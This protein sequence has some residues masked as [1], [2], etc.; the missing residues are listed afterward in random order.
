[1]RTEIKF[2]VRNTLGL[3]L[4]SFLVSASFAQQPEQSSPPQTTIRVQTSLVLVDVITQDPK[5]GLPVRDFK[6]EDF[7]VFDKGNE[8]SIAS[9]DA[10]ARYDTRRVV[11]WLAVI[12]NERGRT[13][14][15]SQFVGKEKLFLPALNHLDKLDTVGVAH[16]CDNGETRLDLL[17]TE[18]RQKPIEILTETI[19]PI[20]FQVGGNSSQVGETT[21]RKMVRLIIQDTLRR[22]PQ[23]L[24]VI[25]FLDGDYT[26]QPLSELNELV[27]DF[28]ETSGIVFGIKDARF[29]GLPELQHEQGQIMHYMADET[30]GQFFAAPPEGYS[31]ALD[32]IMMQLHFRYEIGFVPPVIDG[33][34][35]ELK[36]V[37]T[38]EASEKY[39]GVRLRFR[40]EYIPLSE[41]PAWA[42]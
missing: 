39:K 38:K 42:R 20:H 34:R 33:K 10:G 3:V 4:L 1:M 25:V 13:A 30:G 5:S 16:W 24:P 15:S 29:P 9:F 17:P 12:C 36:V 40:P 37:L 27:G 32:E 11:V 26:G 35:H 8:V 23:P 18:D 41:V 28:L 7:R 2:T 31:A 19:Q 6:K 22:N 14:G 21:F